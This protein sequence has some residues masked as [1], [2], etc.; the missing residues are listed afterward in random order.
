MAE[1]PG[2]LDISHLAQEARVSTRTIR[3]YG[4]L[5]LLRATERGPGGRRRYGPDAL[6]RLRFIGRLKALGLTLAEIQELNSIFAERS[7]SG[8][9]D[10]LDELLGS[11]RRELDA[12]IEELNNLRDDL[13]VYHQ[14]ILRR[15]SELQDT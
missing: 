7:T 6:E 4:E 15:R 13:D 12:R 9:L 3:Y 5:G 2:H 1:E 10:H 11:R 14:K 8:M